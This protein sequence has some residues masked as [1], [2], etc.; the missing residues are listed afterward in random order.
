M[1]LTLS[2]ISEDTFSLDGAPILMT[3]LKFVLL[4]VYENMIDKTG[5]IKYRIF[6]AKQLYGHEIV[7]NLR[8]NLLCKLFFKNAPAPSDC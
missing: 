2:K 7:T 3:N 1:N 4:L 8:E 5:D 6:S